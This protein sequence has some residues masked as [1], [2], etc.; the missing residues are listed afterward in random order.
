MLA[1]VL[2]A[3][4]AGW[5]HLRLPALAAYSGITCHLLDGRCA[6]YGTP[7]SYQACL[8]GTLPRYVHLYV[9]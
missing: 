2:A 4:G 7:F 9:F 1:T 5:S 3:G 8:R 6:P